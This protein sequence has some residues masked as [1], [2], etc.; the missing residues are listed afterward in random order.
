MRRIQDMLIQLNNDIPANRTIDE[1]SGLVWTDIPSNAA[2]PP[3]AKPLSPAPDL[4]TNQG[5]SLWKAADE[6]WGGTPRRQAGRLPHFRAV[7]GKASPPR[8][9]LQ[10]QDTPRFTRNG[11][12]LCNAGE[13]GYQCRVN[14]ILPSLLACNLL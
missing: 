10:H 12:R 3:V 11:L 14:A 13:S 2:P 4:E 1:S 9:R 8:G 7:H 5:A 6:S